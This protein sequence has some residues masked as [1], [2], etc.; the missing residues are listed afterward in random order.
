MSLSQNLTPLA[1]VPQND[2]LQRFSIVCLN[3]KTSPGSGK[4]VVAENIRQEEVV[5][6]IVA[7]VNACAGIPTECLELGPEAVTPTPIYQQ[8]QHKRKELNDSL[9]QVAILEMQRDQL[10]AA[11]ESTVKAWEK[12]DDV[13]GGIQTARA[14]IAAVKGGAS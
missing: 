10:L 3:E 4:L 13:F 7:C 2:R 5:Q 9:G 6:R 14:A 11:L 12:G 1:V 8:L